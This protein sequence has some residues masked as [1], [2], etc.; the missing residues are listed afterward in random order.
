[1]TVYFNKNILTPD[2]SLS[3]LSAFFDHTSWEIVSSMASEC[4]TY[5]CLGNLT[6]SCILESS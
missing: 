1:M 3:V 5:L 4:M 2:F 6:L